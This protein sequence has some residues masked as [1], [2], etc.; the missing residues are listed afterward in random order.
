MAGTLNVT[1]SEFVVSTDVVPIITKITKHKLTSRNYL[2]WRQTIE[3]YLLSMSMDA[4]MTDDP[5]TD[6]KLKLIWQRD[7]ARYFLKIINSISSDVVLLV[8]HCRNAKALMVYLEFLYSGKG[9]ISRM[10]D[11]CQAFYKP[12]KGDIRMTDY[13]MEFR[14]FTR[15]STSC[16]LLVRTIQFN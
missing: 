7:D 15:S 9:N 10:Y 5:L 2:D 6:Y 3:L 13:Y 12:D 11:I 4:H 1:F 8:T 16:L 14:I